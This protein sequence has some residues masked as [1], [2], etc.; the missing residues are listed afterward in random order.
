MKHRISRSFMIILAALGYVNCT[1]K[2]PA[3]LDLFNPQNVACVVGSE[4]DDAQRKDIY[5]QIT[6]F[7][8]DYDNRLYIGDLRTRRI[9]KFDKYGCY[10]LSFGR[11]GQGPGEFSSGVHAFCSDSRGFVFV[12]FKDYIDVFD[13][14]GAYIEKIAYPDGMRDWYCLMMRA[15]HADNLLLSLNN[16]NNEFKLI[17]YDKKNK[18]YT[19]I[20]DEN[21]RAGR[22]HNAFCRFNPD[23]D[24]D[25]QDNIYV[26]DSV[27]YRVFVYD[28]WGKLIKTLQKTMRKTKMSRKELY[29]TPGNHVIEKFPNT[30]LDQ[31]RGAASYYPIL[32]GINIDNNRLF[33]WRTEQDNQH[34]HKIDIYD[35]Q[36]KLIG[37]SSHYNIVYRNLVTFRNGFVY[38]MNIGDEDLDFKKK[39]GI[40]RAYNIPNKVICYKYAEY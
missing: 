11:P 39:L 6:E 23:F 10:M 16:N 25:S 7:Y 21:Q 17:K 15:D 28:P 20:H 29:Y 32:C 36:F 19:H 26:I 40:L 24:V 4:F 34:K 5:S 27:E 33:L 22:Y 9:D 12:S 37:V 30:P 8:V 18:K 31:L 38:F 13:D 35:D 3:W 2:E 14:R 1:P